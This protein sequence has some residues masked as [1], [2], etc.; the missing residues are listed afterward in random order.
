MQLKNYRLSIVL[1]VVSFRALRTAFALHPY[2]T[3]TIYVILYFGV[4]I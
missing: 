4:L 3:T 1:S 2:F